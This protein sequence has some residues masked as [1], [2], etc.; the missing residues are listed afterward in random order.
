MYAKKNIGELQNAAEQFGLAPAL[1]ARFARKDLGATRSGFSY[2]RMA[3]GL[4]SGFG[5]RHRDQ[6]ETYV[7]LSGGGRARIGDDDVP[8]QRFD[9]LLV[10]PDAWRAF[11]AGADGLE[12]LV[13]GAGEADD[14]EMDPGF[15]P[16]G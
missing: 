2:Q 5:H 7:V 15:W 11:E 9:V 10:S 8:L 12:L 3:P 14:T 13:F 1:E 16:A 6:E 4:R